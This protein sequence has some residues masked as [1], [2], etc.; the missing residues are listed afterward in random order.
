MAFSSKSE[1]GIWET[2]RQ[3]LLLPY[4]RA[5][6]NLRDILN[7]WSLGVFT[8]KQLKLNKYYVLH[9]MYF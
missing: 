7:I 4:F 5:I 2:H 1:F 3:I 9:P 8:D 6:E